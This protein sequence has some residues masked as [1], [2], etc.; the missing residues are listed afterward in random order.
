MIGERD[1]IYGDHRGLS[2]LDSLRRVSSASLM[3]S[4]VSFPDST[5]R[6]ITGF[7]LPPKRLSSSSI[8]RFWAASREIAASK[9]LAL[10]IRFTQRT[11]FLRSIRYTVV[12]IVVYASRFFSGKLSWISRIEQAQRF[13]NLKFKF[14]QF[15]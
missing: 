7:G 6:A 2:F 4:S 11:A 9:M 5:R 14:R 13:H 12:W 3:S 15:G 10:L 8:N 1:E